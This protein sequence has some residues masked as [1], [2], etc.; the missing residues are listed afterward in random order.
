M[1]RAGEGAGRM[2]WAEAA[3]RGLGEERKGEEAAVSGAWWVG[4]DPGV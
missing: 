3:A 1:Q 2:F 4:A